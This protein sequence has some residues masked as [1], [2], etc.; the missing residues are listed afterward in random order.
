MCS[1]GAADWSQVWQGL[2]QLSWLPQSWTLPGERQGRGQRRDFSLVIVDSRDWDPN[3]CCWR[4]MSHGTSKLSWLE[5]V[6]ASLHVFSHQAEPRLAGMVAERLIYLIH[7][8]P[9]TVQRGN[10]SGKG[11]PKQ[12]CARVETAVSWRKDIL[13][14]VISMIYVVSDRE[15]NLKCFMFTVIPIIYTIS[16]VCNLKNNQVP[17]CPLHHSKESAHLK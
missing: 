8:L 2:Y 7:H 10:S 11:C 17:V 12:V 3:L 1:V 4:P 13:R 9:R 14:N 16:K 5:W 15:T 6:R